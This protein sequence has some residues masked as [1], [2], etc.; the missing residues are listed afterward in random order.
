MAFSKK[1][2]ENRADYSISD[3]I[4]WHVLVYGTRPKGNPTLKAWKPWDLDSLAQ[5]LDVDERTLRNWMSGKT[6]CTKLGEL[7]DELFGN[8]PLFDEWRFELFDAYRKAL[9]DETQGLS[10]RPEPQARKRSKDRP[11]V[12][13]GRSDLAGVSI[14]ARG[15][16]KPANEDAETAESG[17]TAP[18][19]DASNP[20][21]SGADHAEASTF[22]SAEPEPGHPAA[23]AESEKIES[24][25]TS[26]DKARSE[27]VRTKNPVVLI[28]EPS[29]GSTDRYFRYRKRIAIVGV[30][31]TMLMGLFASTRLPGPI[32]QKPSDDATKTV[33]P[34]PA[35][36]PTPSTALPSTTAT[37]L[38]KQLTTAPTIPPAPP[39]SAPSITINSPTV[40]P[41]APPQAVPASPNASATNLPQSSTPAAKSLSLPDAGAAPNVNTEQTEA[42]ATP[43][44]VPQNSAGLEL[45]PPPSAPIDTPVPPHN[46]GVE[47][48]IPQAP[49]PA[50]SP[51][52][53]SQPH[54]GSLRPA[55]SSKQLDEWLAKLAGLG[56]PEVLTLA[57]RP[58]A[59]SQPA[60]QVS[61][62][63]SPSTEKLEEI[64][65]KL[66]G[67]A[68][69]LTCDRKAA[70]AWDPD[71]IGQHLKGA[72]FKEY[73]DTLS[74]VEMC[75]KAVKEEPR[76]RRLWFQLGRSYDGAQN[77]NKAKAA[78]DTAAKLGSSSA[79]VNI[80]VL[81]A[82][83]SI[84]TVADRPKARDYYRRAA[85][86]EN[87]EG[88]YQYATSLAFDDKAG[89]LDQT[90][91]KLWFKRALDKS[92]VNPGRAEDALRRLQ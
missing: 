30:G 40:A 82:Q 3:L 76:N 34:K 56:G 77:F 8:N 73:K 57:A 89:T 46:T 75:N 54:K 42:P 14:N 71:A 23:D 39:T 51:A 62:R 7:A 47:A 53:N 58:P 24:R 35:P 11:V 59:S 78:Y 55:P 19:N 49:T 13:F 70:A 36:A 33:A 50:T 52:A 9:L 69:T 65:E 68:P 10:E 87:P 15:V 31:L 43:I 1:L 48:S 88:M 85:V 18:R 26:T 16:G 20:T 12:P 83:G 66:G 37:P 63:S 91:A 60:K 67:L 64:L 86:Q 22:S 6:R 29:A 32:P 45:K 2:P 21:V 27:E 81:Y 80:G 28:K 17:L 41:P 74:S 61:V 90:E 38:S 72:E 92:M 25:K 79:L 5:L 84:G 4:Y 44:V